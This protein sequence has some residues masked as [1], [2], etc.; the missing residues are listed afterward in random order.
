MSLKCF[1]FYAMIPQKFHMMPEPYHLDHIDQT[2]IYNV[3]KSYLQ[4]QSTWNE[5]GGMA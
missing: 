2:Y 1:V 5:G 3:D 4:V